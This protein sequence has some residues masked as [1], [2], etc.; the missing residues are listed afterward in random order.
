MQ[1]LITLWKLSNVREFNEIIANVK[2]VPASSTKTIHT[3]SQRLSE[4][5][6]H[7]FDYIETQLNKNIRAWRR[8]QQQAPEDAKQSEDGDYSF[9]NLSSVCKVI[10]KFE[11]SYKQLRKE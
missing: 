3:V 9:D 1:S 7:N 5:F 2:E 8:I 4:T 11:K 6:V 10:D